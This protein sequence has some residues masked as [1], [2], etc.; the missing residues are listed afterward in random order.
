MDHAHIVQAWGH[1]LRDLILQYPIAADVLGPLL[2]AL[3]ILGIGICIC[4]AFDA[5]RNRF[6]HWSNRA[7]ISKHHLADL[8]RQSGAAL[9]RAQRALTVTKNTDELL[10]AYKKEQDGVRQRIADLDER[11]TAYSTRAVATEEQAKEMT[12]KFEQHSATVS[13]YI[14][15]FV[16]LEGNLGTLAIRI[17]N[18]EDRPAENPEWFTGVDRALHNHDSQLIG[19]QSRLRDLTLPKYKPA[20]PE[21]KRATTAKAPRKGTR[22]RK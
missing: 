21:Q 4:F 9:A 22:K 15:D 6:R 2:I 1:R 8:I 19:V 12:R 14:S 10:N 3:V 18:L 7:Y 17:A 16:R 13:R 11:L 5:V 20:P